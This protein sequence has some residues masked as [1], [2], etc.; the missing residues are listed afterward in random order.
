MKVVVF[1]LCV[2]GL[3]ALF[4]LRVSSERN[5][6]YERQWSVLADA[7]LVSMEQG[8]YARAV[9]QL[10]V[11]LKNAR[12]CHDDS[13]IGCCLHLLAFAYRT[14]GD[15]GKAE[16]CWRQALAPLKRTSGGKRHALCDVL[17]ALSVVCIDKGRYQEAQDLANQAVA[18]SSVTFGSED[19]ET[20]HTLDA[21]ANVRRVQRR[22]K[23]SEAIFRGALAIRRKAGDKPDLDTANSLNGLGLL[24]LDMGRLKE[25]EATLRQELAIRQKGLGPREPRLA[26]CMGDLA[27]LRYRQGDYSEARQLSQ[28]AL[29]ITAP[30]LGDGQR[31]SLRFLDLCVRCDLRLGDYSHAEPLVG[32][33]LRSYEGRYGADSSHLVTVLGYHKRLLQK[34]G[35]W[36]DAQVVSARI[37]AIRSTGQP[38]RVRETEDRHRR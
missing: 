5:S 18:E 17:V 22:Y 20:A 2:A 37:R 9:R 33:L 7:S 24:Y 25:A 30:A 21:L 26:V 1:M 4:W 27:A 23:E 19:L 36:R 28:A 35:R 6:A 12:R 34:T 13:A 8:D 10:N 38:V 29:T 16:A 3:A 11:A 32:R 31:D 14:L 15:D